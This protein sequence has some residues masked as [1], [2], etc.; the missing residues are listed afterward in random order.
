MLYWGD[1]LAIA[2]VLSVGSFVL[3][4]IYTIQRLKK[5]D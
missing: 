3:G 5:E 4:I 2:I 1:Y